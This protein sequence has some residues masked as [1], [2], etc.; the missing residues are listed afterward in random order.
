MQQ[1]WMEPDGS[2]TFG[3]FFHGAGLSNLLFASEGTGV[4]EGWF[5]LIDKRGEGMGEC[6]EVRLRVRWY[7]DEEEQRREMGQRDKH[8]AAAQRRAPSLNEHRGLR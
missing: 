6:G 5:P 4:I 3:I 1:V 7:H 2:M 8:N